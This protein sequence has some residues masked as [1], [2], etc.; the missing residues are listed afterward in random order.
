MGRAGWVAGLGLRSFASRRM[1]GCW[2]WSRRK[3]TGAGALVA[4]ERKDA[5]K[6]AGATEVDVVGSVA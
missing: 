2:N 4:A 6:G 1:T 5:G 3:S